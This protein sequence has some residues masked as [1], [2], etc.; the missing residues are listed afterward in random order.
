MNAPLDSSDERSLS[1]RDALQWMLAAGLAVALPTPA[2][3]EPTLA[4]AA[5]V[6]GKP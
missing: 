4:S 5:P 2:L 3:G 1:R 6:T